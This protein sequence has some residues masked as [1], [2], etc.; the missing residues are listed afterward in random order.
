MPKWKG[1]LANEA[2]E[3]MTATEAI[4]ELNQVVSCVANVWVKES[5]VST[6]KRKPPDFNIEKVSADRKSKIVKQ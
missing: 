3:E 2:E 4:V 5:G 6:Q 1:F